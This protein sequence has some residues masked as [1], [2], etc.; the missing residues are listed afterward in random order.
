MGGSFRQSGGAFR[1]DRLKA[2][3]KDDFEVGLGRRENMVNSK[4]SY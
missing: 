1:E 2:V 3:M 4:K